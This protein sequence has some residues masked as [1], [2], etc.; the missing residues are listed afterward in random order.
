MVYILRVICQDGQLL[1]VLPH[2]LYPLPVFIR[3][4]QQFRQLVQF[5]QLR[6][7][8]ELDSVPQVQGLV[9][10][11]YLIVHQ[12]MEIHEQIFAHA[13]QQIR[14]EHIQLL[15]QGMSSQPK[16]GSGAAGDSLGFQN[17]AEQN[18][19]LSARHCNPLGYIFP[20]LIPSIQ[21]QDTGKH[22]Y[23]RDVQLILVLEAALRVRS[24]F[25]EIGALQIRGGLREIHGRMGDLV[26]DPPAYGRYL[27]RQGQQEVLVCPP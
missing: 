17:R 25:P 13:L 2:L 19:S 1:I 23:R 5:S 9:G 8:Q 6:L 12:G 22:G 15:V 3:F 11:E 7:A 21:I 18:G 14:R 20:P 27:V 16:P 4:P 26:A 10:I 24:E